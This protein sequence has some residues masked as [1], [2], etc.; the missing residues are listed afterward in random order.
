MVGDGTSCPLCDGDSVLQQMKDQR[1]C[2]MQK[3][4][5]AVYVLCLSLQT[6]HTVSWEADTYGLHPYVSGLCS[7]VS[8][9]VWSV[10]TG[11]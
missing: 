8:H 10:V 6:H 2:W 7:Y 9:W 11:E 3:G 4:L 1:R 5:G